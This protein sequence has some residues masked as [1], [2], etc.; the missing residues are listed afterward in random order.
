MPYNVTFSIEYVNRTSITAVQVSDGLEGSG[1]L[2]RA[3]SQNGTLLYRRRGRTVI[4]GRLSVT[5]YSPHVA[6]DALNACL[7][8]WNFRFILQISDVI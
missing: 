2:R 8:R 7:A 1:R 3:W 6:H 4:R 5:L